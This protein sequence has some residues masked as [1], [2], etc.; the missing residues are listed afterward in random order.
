MLPPT[1]EDVLPEGMPQEQT[2]A[3]TAG[4][5]S[6]RQNLVATICAVPYQQYVAGKQSKGHPFMKPEAWAA[7]LM[8]LSGPPAEFP[9]GTMP[10]GGGVAGAAGTNPEEPPDTQDYTNPS[11]ATPKESGNPAPG[12][13]PPQVA[14]ST[15]P[16]PTGTGRV[17]AA[18]KEKAKHS[19]K[20]LVSLDWT[21]GTCTSEKPLTWN[22]C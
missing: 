16:A 11:A 17:A 19:D 14:R 13:P 21:S 20:R 3:L 4:L 5:A 8:G 15:A 2:K 22:D 6:A 9:S 10:Q 1:A 18:A 12:T 7:T